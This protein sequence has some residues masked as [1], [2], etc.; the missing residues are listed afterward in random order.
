M[1]YKGQNNEYLQLEKIINYNSLA[2]K[3][4]VDNPL[5]L[6]WFEKDGTKITIDN[7]SY[8]FNANQIICMTEFHIENGFKKNKLEK[9][10]YWWRFRDISL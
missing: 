4:S 10:N 9:R 5:T 8:V 6:L 2:P 1:I 3:E 7:I